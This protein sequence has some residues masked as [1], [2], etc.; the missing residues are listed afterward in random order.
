MSVRKL[1]P[2]EYIDFCEICQIVF[3]GVE[4]ADIREMKKNPKKHA[5]KSSNVQLGFFDEKGKLQSALQ[6][7]PYTMRVNNHDVKMG[8]VGAVMTRPESRGLGQMNSLMQAAFLEMKKNSQVFS[9]L[10]PFSFR[11]YRKFGY[12]TCYEYNKIKIPV[13]QMYEYKQAVTVIPFE[14]NDSHEPYAEIYKKF[15]RE[16]NFPIIRD[17]KAWQDILNRDPYLDLQFTYLLKDENGND[18]AYILYSAEQDDDDGNRLIIKECCWKTPK[19]LHL[20]FA[21]LSK[22]GAEYEYAHWNAPSCLNIFALFPEGF[23]LEWTRET[24]GMNRIVNVCAALETLHAPKNNSRVAIFVTDKFLPENSGSYVVE[25][26][27]NIL[28]AQKKDA[29]PDI[30][31][32]VETLAQLVSGYITPETAALKKDTIIHGSLE[33]LIALFPKKHLFITER[34]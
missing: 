27:N 21:F 3:F 5:K 23:E 17:E 13:S 34:Y 4:R 31:T 6:I 30:E 20:V 15:I 10:Y 14:P 33:N 2:V 9:F 26:E 22:L 16:Q 1:K 29:P 24:T 12:E 32:T 7:I 11:Y 19:D 18:A 25:W 28:S 8:G